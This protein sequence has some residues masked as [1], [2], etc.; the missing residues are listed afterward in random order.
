MNVKELIKELK[1]YEEYDLK[2][3]CDEEWNTIFSNFM[4]QRAGKNKVLVI[5]GL[6]GSE[7]EEDY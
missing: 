4:L 2:V 5:A 7:W 1:G 3:A 6:S